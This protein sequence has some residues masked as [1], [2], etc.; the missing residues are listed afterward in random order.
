MCVK[1]GKRHHRWCK[2]QG[3]KCN[4]VN[5]ARVKAI[6]IPVHRVLVARTCN[7]IAQNKKNQA[8]SEYVMTPD[9]A[10]D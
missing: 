7:V 8:I 9:Q 5:E 6:Q 10:M 4:S 1:E 2:M 3:T